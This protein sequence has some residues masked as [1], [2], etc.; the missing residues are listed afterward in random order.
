[1]DR[2]R[3][4]VST[5]LKT[6]PGIETLEARL[7][8]GSLLSSLLGIPLDAEL[9]CARV[10]PPEEQVRRAIVATSR[11]EE[12]ET[13]PALRPVGAPAL[14]AEVS[15]EREV[16]QSLAALP[17]SWMQS[18]ASAPLSLLAGAQAIPA[19]RL[20]VPAAQDA[21]ARPATAALQA[22]I[23]QQGSSAN[24]LLGS[25]QL[26]TS[27]LGRQAVTAES[28]GVQVREIE[29][30]VTT[31]RFENEP[32]ITTELVYSTYFGLDGE[33]AGLAIVADGAGNS[34]ATGYFGFGEDRDLFV[35]KVNAQG[36]LDWVSFFGAPGADEGHGIGV[37]AAGNVYVVGFYTN[38]FE[39]Q[40]AI[41]G[42][43]AGDGSIQYVLGFENA[44]VDSAN[45]LTMAGDTFF[46]TGTL[47]TETGSNLLAAQF[48]L[49]G[50]G[51]YGITL[52][53]GAGPSE[54]NAI[55]SDK[56]G[57]TYLVGTLNEGGVDRQVLFLSLDAGATPRYAFTL[58]HAGEDTG[59]GVHLSGGTLYM[60]GQFAGEKTEFTD[61]FIAQAIADDGTLEALTLLTSGVGSVVNYGIV[62]DDSGI[63][64]VA[65]SLSLGKGNLEG[66]VVKLIPDVGLDYYMMAGS[67][68]DVA[69]ALSRG[70]NNSAYVVGKTTS[71]DFPVTEGAFQPTYGGGPSDAWGALFGLD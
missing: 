8:P 28:H 22:V 17:A 54:G 59:L 26:D 40:E 43:F 61:G 16:V 67:G 23:P 60:T 29:I 18:A 27:E 31:Y 13:I 48:T 58:L 6:R 15:A 3:K 33:D 30:P 53:F 38:E 41:V 47:A 44:G 68:Q 37:D 55:A 32:G 46:V 66:I 2:I 7:Q 20:S 69:Y 25:A 50:S 56:S 5:S 14:R 49:D 35:T 19:Q 63:P 36:A 70:A 42:R 71:E 11:I 39:D 51:L 12:L 24:Q 9:L 57:N 34:Y 62:V 10:G 52:A 4:S 65:G 21:Q 1:M 45:G 64:V